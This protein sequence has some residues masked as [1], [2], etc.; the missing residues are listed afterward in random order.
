MLKAKGI[1][2]ETPLDLHSQ[3]SGYSH[4]IRTAEL[5]LPTQPWFLDLQRLAYFQPLVRPLK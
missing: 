3:P 1:E 5:P 4:K 2:P